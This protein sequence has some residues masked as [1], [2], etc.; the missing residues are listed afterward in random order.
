MTFG[1]EVSQI[2]PALCRREILGSDKL[3][4]EV[5]VGAVQLQDVQISWMPLTTFRGVSDAQ[6]SDAQETD[7]RQRVSVLRALEEEGYTPAS[8]RSYA[9]QSS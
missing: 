4:L 3:T 1:R 2:F 9:A 7:A 5:G 8:A 6:V